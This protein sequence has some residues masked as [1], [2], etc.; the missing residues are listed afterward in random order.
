MKIIL[1]ALTALTLNACSSLGIG[2]KETRSINTVACSG[3]ELWP[4]CD[5]KAKSF[6][7]NG[8][9]VIKRDESQVQQ[10]RI[11]TFYCN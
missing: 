9:D 11:M 6:C 1:I 5:T 3:F 2:T 4:D 10:R 8:Y 7:A